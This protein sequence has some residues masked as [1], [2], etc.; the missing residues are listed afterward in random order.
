MKG[1]IPQHDISEVAE[2]WTRDLSNFDLDPRIVEMEAAQIVKRYNR[3]HVPELGGMTE[4][5]PAG[6][7]RILGGQL[8]SAST[9]EVRDRK[10]HK[11]REC[12]ISTRWI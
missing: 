5:K 7:F 9:R 12:G 11:S 8:N 4:E 2:D 10:M 6:V 3:W 1:R